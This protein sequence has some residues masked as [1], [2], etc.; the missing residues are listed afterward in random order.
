[1]AVEEPLEAAD[2]SQ[3]KLQDWLTATEVN[4]LALSQHLL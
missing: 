4:E 1:M 2:Q 3:L